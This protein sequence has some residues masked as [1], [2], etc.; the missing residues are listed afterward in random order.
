[1]FERIVLLSPCFDNGIPAFE[2]VRISSV[3]VVKGELLPGFLALRPKA[4]FL[5]LNAWIRLIVPATE[6]TLLGHLKLPPLD[7][8]REFT[9]L[10]R[11]KLFKKAKTSL[12]GSYDGKLRNI[13]ENKGI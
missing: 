1:M 12:F 7:G 9:L 2:I 5:V 4:G 6:K 8:I 3:P 13:R 11:L 10:L